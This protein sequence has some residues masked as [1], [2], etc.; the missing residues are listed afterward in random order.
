MDEMK[1]TTDVTAHT[2]TLDVVHE[3]D[4]SSDEEGVASDTPHR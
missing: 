4:H 3:A 2:V 1:K